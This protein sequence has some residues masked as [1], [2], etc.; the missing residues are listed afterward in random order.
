MDSPTMKMDGLWYIPE[1]LPADVFQAMVTESQSCE[2]RFVDE[3]PSLAIGRTAALAPAGGVAYQAFGG[4]RFASRLKRLLDLNTPLALAP[5][6]P[7]EYRKYTPGVWMQWHSDVPV[8]EPPQLELVYT[9]ENTSDSVTRW[10]HDHLDV[11]RDRVDQAWTSPNSAI[12]VRAGG[13]VHMVSELSVGRRVIA[14]VMLAVGRLPQLNE[15]AKSNIKML[16]H[17]C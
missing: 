1:L 5:Q 16:E 13:P 6:F 10:A 12:I 11:I 15:D 14:K 3:G 8:M 17:L 7:I 2:N 4:E 9:I